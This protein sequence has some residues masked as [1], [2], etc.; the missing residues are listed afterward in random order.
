MTEMMSMEVQA[1][2]PLGRA[3]D[4]VDGIA[5]VSG[6]AMYAADYRPASDLAE[7]FIVEAPAAPGRIR[8]LDVS[9]AEDAEGV[10]AVLTSANVPEQRAYGAPEDAGRFTQSHAVLQGDRVRHV[11]QPVALIVARTLEQARHAASLV[12]VEIEV[13]AE[14]GIF[15]ALAHEDLA[16]APDSLDGA[17]DAD[18]QKGDLARELAGSDHRVRA[19]YHTAMQHAAAMEPHV[20][21]AEWDGDQ[22]TVHMGIQI[23]ASAVKAFAT[24][25]KIE[26]EQ[27]RIVSPFTGGG[28]GS[29]LGIHAEA[30]L[31][32]LAARVCDRPVRVVQTRRSVFVNAPHRERHRQ[33]LE[34]GATADGTLRAIRHDNLAGMARDYA[35]AEA[36]AS[37]TR[38]SYA[39]PAI[40]TSHRVVAADIPTVDSMRAPGE[41][42][43]TLT[44]ET[45]IDEMAQA[46]GMDPLE[47]R[48]RNM[49]DADPVSGAP[50]GDHRLEACLREGAQRFG[51]VGSVAPGSRREGRLLIG[52]GLAAA[53]RPN[54]LV[55]AEAEIILSP[56]GRFHVRT[57]MTDIG[58]G[59]YTILTQI[60]ADT[61]GVE[62]GQVVT[63]LGD[64]AFPKSSGSGGSFGAAS[65]GSA[66]QD[67]ASNL[68]AALRDR[69]AALGLDGNGALAFTLDSVRLGE[70]SLA[71]AD[72]V[73]P[74]GMTAS[75]SIDPD[76][77]DTGQA[78]YSYGAQFAEVA[79]D[80][81]TGEIRLRR[82]L[83]VFDAGRILNP[84]TARSQLLGGM[85]FGIGAALMEEGVIDPRSGAV[86]AR[87][88][89]DYHIP[90]NRDVPALEVHMLGAS[91]PFAN[92]LGAKGIGELGI[93]G[94]GPAIANAVHEA[95]GV[96]PRAF[97]I[98]LDHLLPHLPRI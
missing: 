20:S 30:V 15:D 11:G 34:L 31:A 56:D 61:L 69:C 93:C 16:F 14:G 63:E 13:D 42:I 57:D 29:K 24:T 36:P 97:P 73:G 32:A 65:T 60:A 74:E 53:I 68:L 39:A 94:A 80:A 26:P 37:P 72:L 76:D 55:G 19:T 86:M 47:F 78:G 58:T 21:V 5:K 83:G 98:H 90:V 79:V 35:F 41:A 9:R 95:T 91:S 71:L 62:P 54:M 4:R 77:F 44:L 22:L 40:H 45:A 70:R 23:V 85:I 82:L 87:D 6:R 46:C 75:G 18:T 3:L 48:L 66:V 81:V 49:L 28:F 10:I 50:F 12:E 43:G 88:L 51:W 25:L 38:A 17:D 52:R 2:R 92:P 59:S 33:E 1:E 89:A 8:R 64:S 96:R 27:I 84:K 7:G 67:A